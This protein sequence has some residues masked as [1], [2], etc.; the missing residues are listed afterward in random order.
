[1]RKIKPFI[2]DIPFVILLMNG[3]LVFAAMLEAGPWIYFLMPQLSGHGL[4]VLF[5]AGYFAKL[6]RFCIY[7]WICLGA[8]AAL[9]VLNIL[10]YWL[11]FS[12]YELYVCLLVYPILIMYVIYRIRKRNAPTQ[13]A[14]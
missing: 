2:R 11:Q 1:M 7:T 9:N 10:Y 12:Y 4:I 13:I 5:Y 6:H 3:I 8:L 14:I